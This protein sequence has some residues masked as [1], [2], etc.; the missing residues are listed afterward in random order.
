MSRSSAEETFSAQMYGMDM[1]RPLLVLIAV[2]G[3]LIGAAPAQA[4]WPIPN[5]PVQ[6]VPCPEGNIIEG[7]RVGGCY[8]GGVIYVDPSLPDQTFALWHE[9]GHVLDEQ[10]INAGERNRFRHLVMQAQSTTVAFASE[11]WLIRQAGEA[12]K[13]SPGELFADA[14]ATCSLQQLPNSGDFA[15]AYGYMPST[16][17]S[18]QA[19]CSFIDRATV[20]PASSK[21][22]RQSPGTG[23]QRQRQTRRSESRPARLKQRA[24]WR[25]Y[26]RAALRFE[27]RAL[28]YA[29]TTQR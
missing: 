24:S 18:A 1:F 23:S 3:L 12:P 29:L 8:T 7:V 19:I 5:V 26:R 13:S 25:S 27:A 2:A 22:S 21:S 14:Y 4:S 28:R 6:W 17:E 16:N 10:Q 9:R 20:S 11:S 15:V